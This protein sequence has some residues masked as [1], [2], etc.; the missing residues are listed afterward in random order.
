MNKQAGKEM[1]ILEVDLC[2]WIFLKIVFYYI[3]TDIHE[4]AIS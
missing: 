4:S 2:L 1:H 3:N